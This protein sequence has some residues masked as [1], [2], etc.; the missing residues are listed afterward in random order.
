MYSPLN[1]SKIYFS[2]DGKFVTRISGMD[3]QANMPIIAIHGN[4]LVFKRNGFTGWVSRGEVG[5]YNP[6]YYLVELDNNKIKRV[7]EKTEAN[8]DTW[9]E[10][11]QRL[12]S[13]AILMANE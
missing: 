7:I 10:V 4:Y 11:R 9:R 13:T 6:D 12:C 8:K 2:D 3:M 1:N 5:Y